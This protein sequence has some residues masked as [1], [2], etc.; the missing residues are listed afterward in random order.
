MKRLDSQSAWR[1]KL[2]WTR[3]SI[4]CTTSGC[5]D[6]SSMVVSLLVLFRRADWGSSSIPRWYC[7]WDASSDTDRK[8][9]IQI[10]KSRCAAVHWSATHSRT[11]STTRK[12]YSIHSQSSSIHLAV[13]DHPVYEGCRLGQY[14]Q[15]EYSLP[16]NAY[17]QT[18]G[19]NL[20][21]LPFQGGHYRW[22]G[23]TGRIPQQR[24]CE[25]F[26]M[27]FQTLFPSQAKNKGI[28]IS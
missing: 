14:Q 25:V 18:R 19:P 7:F 28:M 5:W 21:L 22:K 3:E 26:P 10:C 16:V 4:R 1:R 24:I 23:R 9:R 15:Q 12:G 6:V 17:Q 27:S 11:Y 13:V 20:L 8:D 2:S